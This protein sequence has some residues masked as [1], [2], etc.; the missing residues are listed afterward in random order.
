MTHRLIEPFGARSTS[1]LDGFLTVVGDVLW[2]TQDTSGW[3]RFV[4]TT[5]SHPLIYGD[6]LFV[7]VILG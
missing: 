1:L 2:V 5:T 6:V 4:L 3:I 7:E